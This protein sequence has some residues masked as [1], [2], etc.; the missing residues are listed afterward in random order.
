MTREQFLSYFKQHYAGGQHVTLVGPTGRGKTTLALEM[1]AVTPRDCEI[2]ILAGKP[3]KRDKVMTGAAQQ[4]N[5]EIIETHPPS[6][7]SRA[8]SKYKNRRGYVLRP[9]QDLSDDDAAQAEVQRQFERALRSNYKTTGRKTITVVDEGA[10]V[11]PSSAYGGLGLQKRMDA[12]LMRGAPDAS[13]WTLVQR[14][15]FMS[16]HIYDAPEWILI[17]YDPDES[18][19]RRYAEIGGVDPRTVRKILASLETSRVGDGR[20]ISEFLCIR[21]SGPE[22]V[23]IGT[24]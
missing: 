14:G 10:H 13:L 15:R 18:N 3:P 23:I 16:Y 9:R 22:L 20:T 21:R 17:S 8:K 2:T 6:P 11:S 24:A 5:L 12:I 7:Y 19:Q 1:L 4:L